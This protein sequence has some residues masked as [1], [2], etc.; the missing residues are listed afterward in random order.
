[1]KKSLIIIFVTFLALG[2]VSYLRY[3][4]KTKLLHNTNSNSSKKIN[5]PIAINQDTLADYKNITYTLDGQSVTF[6]NGLAETE[7]VKDSGIK[8]IFKYY[9][10]EVKHDFNGDGLEDI[11]FIISNETGGTGTF[12]F[13]VVA[14]N[15]PNGYFGSNGYFIGD[16]II[17]LYTE[18]GEGYSII[19]NYLDRGAD[20]P[21]SA[22]PA[23]KK[24]IKLLLN[25]NSMEL[26]EVIKN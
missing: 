8:N 16:R 12:F 7:L 21:F 1:M 4:V 20:E 26:N 19:V 25:T 15:T 5:Q 24:S 18:L 6:V 17:P 13:L 9:G 11:A 3:E 22:E 23:I 14:L 2:L 10:N